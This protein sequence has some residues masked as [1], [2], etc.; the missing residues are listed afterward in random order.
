MRWY[1][2][3]YV[4]LNAMENKET[5]I[6][7]IKEGKPQFNKFVLAL[8]L[9]N[10]DILDIYPSY[11]LLQKAYRESSLMIVGIADGME[12]AYDM[13]QLAIMDCYSETKGFN[14]KEFMSEEE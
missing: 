3:L 12:E 14:L 2:D 11:V 5:I 1:K 6:A 7:N 10:H 8:P 4:G 13:V 9:N